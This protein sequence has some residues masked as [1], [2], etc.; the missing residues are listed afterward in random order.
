MTGAAFPADVVGILLNTCG[1]GL[2]TGMIDDS[3]LLTWM[4]S[5]QVITGEDC[6]RAF[7]CERLR[8]HFDRSVHWPTA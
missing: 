4:C 2:K 7:V 5:F 1:E 8:L 6:V 3:R